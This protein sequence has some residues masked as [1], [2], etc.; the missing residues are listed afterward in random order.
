[1]NSKLAAPTDGFVPASDASTILMGKVNAVYAKDAHGLKA[2][3]DGK[4]GFIV[5]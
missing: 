2:A 1:M 5:E 4:V 3:D